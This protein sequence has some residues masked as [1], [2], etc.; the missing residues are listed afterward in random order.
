MDAVAPQVLNVITDARSMVSSTHALARFS[1]TTTS[2]FNAFR[3]GPMR[4]ILVVAVAAFVASP[5][6]AQERPPAATSQQVENLRAFAK[7]YGYVRYFHPSDRAAAVD[8][9]AFAAHGAVQVRD[10]ADTEAL[11]ARLLDLFAPL[12]PT[13]RITHAGET[14][15]RVPELFPADTTGLHVVAWQHVGLGNGMTNSVYR[16]VRTNRETVLTGAFG[17]AVLFQT[18]DAEALRGAS[19]RFAGYGRAVDSGARAQLWLRVD[20]G[21]AMG[22]FD[23]MGDRPVTSQDWSEMEIVGQVDDDASQI[24]LGTLV[25]DGAAAFDALELEI[26]TP[27]GWVRLPLANAGFEEPQDSAAA[28]VP[29]WRFNAR[30]WRTAIDAGDAPEGE[31][32]LRVSQE[33]STIRGP[34]FPAYSQPGD[35]VT[36]PLGR[37]LTAHMP[38]ALWS[39]DGKTVEPDTDSEA[40][41][42]ALAMSASAGRGDAVGGL[43]LAGVIIL[44][45]ALQ[46]FYPYWDVVDADWDAVL[47]EALGRALASETSEPMLAI[48]QGMVHALKDGHGNVIDTNAAPRLRPPF[49]ARWIE[50]RV[51]IVA[52]TESSLLRPG[53]VVL[54]VDGEDAA[55]LVS[56]DMATFSG[57]DSWRRWRALEQFGSGADEV[58]EIRFERDGTPQ[59]VS[60][61]RQM[62]MQPARESR[63]GPVE[64]L[65]EGI[66]YVNLDAAPIDTIR[67]RMDEL[68][69]ARGVVFD[70]RGYPAGNHDILR[71]LTDVPFQSA[72]FLSPQ[73]TRPDWAQPISYRDGRWNMAPAQPR[74]AG[75][76]V[77]LTDERAISYA[78][79]VLGIVEH[80]R[81]GEIVGA[82]TAGANGN[83]NPL[84]LPGGYLVMWTGMRVVKHDGAQH[85]LVGI[86]P[87]V[88][89][90]PT[91]E[92]VRAGRDEVL[93][94]GLEVLHQRL[95][96]RRTS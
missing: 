3:T 44:W 1:S 17:N 88:P 78:E 25:Y 67:N 79:S 76:I 5:A 27:E 93:E 82:P 85:H 21:D 57:S 90:A 6:F 59:D 89:A 43:R 95:L 68:V 87:T 12:A 74:I 77:F 50:D 35:I 18:L 86:Q 60:V 83:V 96:S 65:E 72:H 16:S 48:L 63:P 92:G 64:E 69:A 53:D 47:T 41:R 45:N 62:M 2:L 49:A 31:R 7:L 42:A 91:I 61:E 80:Y 84:R 51:V 23:N 13:L 34:L 10:A 52:A 46:H 26:E 33:T 32:F 36:A 37:D 22:F 15:E 73:I 29:G 14:P 24:V 75:E 8:W 9:D 55:D 56:R 11:R 54:S 94:R 4:S 66:Y 70:L 39:R 71:H 28:A 81:L 20:R 40:L 30:G 38:L 58:V 19:L